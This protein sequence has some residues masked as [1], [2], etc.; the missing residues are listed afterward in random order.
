MLPHQA[1]V[2]TGIKS[3]RNTQVRFISV[4]PPIDDFKTFGYGLIEMD[5][6]IFSAVKDAVK[7]S[8]AAREYGYPPNRSGFICCPFHAERTPSMKLY[9]RTYHCFGCGAHGSVLDFVGGLFN[10]SPL[11]AAKK[12]NVDFGLHLAETPRGREEQEHHRKVQEVRSHYEEWK[13]S[14]LN[15]IDACIRVANLADYDNLSE[16]EVVALRYR[17]ALEYWS[18]I[19]LHEPL[20]EQMRVFRDR[21]EVERLCKTILKS[22]QTRLNTA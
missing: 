19:L 8:E 1:E 14:T 13:S 2:R 6:S 9:D 11:E 17:E 15:L 10:L 22:S 21:R 5:D 4:T 7:V 18:D 16:G 12:I 20:S 3:L